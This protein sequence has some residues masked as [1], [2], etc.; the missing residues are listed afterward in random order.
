MLK[1]NHIMVLFLQSDI[2]YMII[3]IHILFIIQF[4]LATNSV[5]FKRCVNR[6]CL[7][8][9]T[10]DQYTKCKGA[11]SNGQT[12]YSPEVRYGS[13]TGGV[14]NKHSKNDISAW[15]N[16]LFPGTKGTAIYGKSESGKIGK[17]FW[18]RGFDDIR[19]YHWC[20][21]ND[22]KWRSSS[23]AYATK[24]TTAERMTSVTCKK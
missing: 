20:D 1:Y 4:F 3:L 6:W 11:S 24:S 23:L 7:Q 17:L 19:V 15:C 16:Q 13:T 9:G 8:K 22:G 21:W 14:P 2:I 12:C 10:R 5:D 18:C